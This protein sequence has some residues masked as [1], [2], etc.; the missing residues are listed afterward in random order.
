[1]KK[2]IIFFIIFFQLKISSQELLLHYKFDNNFNDSSG[3]N[4]SGNPSGVKFVEDRNGN[5]NSAVSFDGLDDFIDF[6][7]I[8]QLKP[9]LPVS[10]SFWIKYESNNVTDRVVFNTSYKEDVNSG[11]YL[12]SQS[13]T[14]KLAVGYGDGS[15]S[16]TSSNRRGYLSNNII[17]TGI[18]YQIHIVII[19]NNNMKIYLN[20]EETGGVYSG[21]GS[22]L[23]YS[24]GPG[25]LGRH[26]QNNS[27]INSYYFKGVLD[28]FKYYKGIVDPELV[29]SDFNNLRGELCVGENYNLPTISDNGISGSWSPTFDSSLIGTTTYTFTPNSNECANTTSHTI[30]I[31][32]QVTPFFSNLETTLCEGSTYNF[33]SVSDNGISG[34]WSPTFDGSSIGTTNYTFTP[35]SGECINTITH[36]IEIIN[37]VTP[38]FSNLETTLCEGSTYNFPLV[39]DNGI[40]GSWSPVFDGSSIGTTN[41]SFIPD[42]NHCSETFN[43]SINI[44]NKTTPSFFN[45]P[46]LLFLETNYILPK[47]S[48]EGIEGSWSPSFD[49]S[50]LGTTTYI[51]IPKNLDCINTVVHNITITQELIIPPFFTPNNDNIND[52]WRIEGLIYYKEV[53]LSIFDRYGKLLSNPD[54]SLGWDGTYNGEKMPSNDYWY[55]LKAI[56]LNNN[57]IL[58]KGHFSLL[59]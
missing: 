42:T 43:H 20:C 13:S 23:V 19:S 24:S 34:S 50:V 57:V 44:K 10:F 17:N 45:L 16:F 21:T 55:L 39:S 59:R 48:I 8:N 46:N 58:K 54:I 15:S 49:S 29:N 14:G 30:E 1:M 6:P 37:Q 53:N 51:F 4:F 27:S 5:P 18:W 38:V 47:V 52:F 7:N 33:P 40:S 9:N 22:G 35:D 41:Y 36:T 32:N 26:D 12:T 56:D 31:T 2:G 11:I 28:D 3:N 25:S